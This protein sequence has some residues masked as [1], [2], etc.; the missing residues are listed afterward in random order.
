MYDGIYNAVPLF[1]IGANLLDTMYDGIYNGKRAHAPDL[2][3]VLRRAAAAG[4]TDLI[5]TSG[6]LE[7]SRRALALV[8]SLR[9]SSP[10]RLSCTVGVH[11]TRC[12]EF[13]Q[14]GENG[15]PPT[16][17]AQLLEVVRDGM[18]DG[19]VVAIGE[20]GL[21]YDRLHFCAVEVQQRGFEVQLQLAES[22]GLPLFLH[23]RNTSGAFA[24]VMCAHKGLRGVV[25]SFDGGMDEMRELTA[26]GLFIGINGCSLRTEENLRVAASVPLGKLLI[27]T[28]APWCQVR[29]THAGAKLVATKFAEVKKESWSA[30]SCVKSRNEPSHCRQVL[31]ILAAIR[32]YP[33]T[34]LGA[35]VHQNARSLF[36]GGASA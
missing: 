10:V 9:A 33:V 31:E 1:D 6:S 15:A 8:R 16:T 25:H 17:A 5:V 35:A 7:D 30:E 26:L 28:D 20:I 13:E 23:N 18:A 29:P 32:E 22:T 11:P 24:A 34:E 14:P 12:D 3:H 4:V 36:Y 21:D 2:E 19:S 27:E